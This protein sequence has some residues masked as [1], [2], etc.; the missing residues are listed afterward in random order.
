MTQ[1]IKA[2]DLPGAGE[3]RYRWFPIRLYTYVFGA[4]IFGWG[5]GTGME[6]PGTGSLVALTIGSILTIVGYRFMRPYIAMAKL[7]IKQLQAARVESNDE[8]APN[9]ASH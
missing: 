6:A 4:G 8:E 9:D 1:Q 7:E 3:P 5:V 2:A